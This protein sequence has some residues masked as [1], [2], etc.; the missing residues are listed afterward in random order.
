M[1]MRVSPAEFEIASDGTIDRSLVVQ[2]EIEQVGDFFGEQSPS[3]VYLTQA[4]SSS[5]VVIN[6]INDSLAEEDG[7]VTLTLHE[8][9]TYRVGKQRVAAVSISDIDDRLRR[10]K[11][12]T[13]AGQDVLP[14]LVGM[15]GAR[16]NEMTTNRVRNAFTATGSTAKFKINGANQFTDLLTVGGELVNTNS[17]SLRSILGSSSFT[18]DL[19]PEQDYPSL[20]TIWGLGDYR[21]LSNNSNENSNSWK[22][23]FFTGQ[24]GFDAMIG[25]G[26]LAGFST[27]VIESDVTHTGV[28]EDELIFRTSLNALNSYFGWTSADKD[29]QLMGGIG[30]GLGDIRL[31]QE[32]YNTEVLNSQFFTLGLSGDHQLYSSENA[33]GSGKTE[34][35][36]SGE[37]WK[38]HHFVNGIIGKFKD[39]ET[40]GGHYQLVAIGSH[41]FILENSTSLTPSA[42]IGLRRDQKNQDSIFGLELDV[43]LK[44]SNLLGFSLSGSANTL[45]VDYDKIQKW[46][47]MGHLTYDQGSDKLGTVLE[48]SPLNRTN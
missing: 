10:S 21:D 48:I 5:R 25:Q 39:L 40:V 34:L 2:F 37:L 24:F 41:E 8:N 33:L 9:N 4:E 19:F 14:D 22:G 16:S 35:S 1:L 11:A 13:A 3:Q 38:M 6:T 36:V 27:S 18:I 12:I 42:S 17:K 45:I 23:D 32:N 28:V 7:L 31:E 43:G 29:T 26:I 20:T 47:L 15:I 30:Y 46:C 44:Y